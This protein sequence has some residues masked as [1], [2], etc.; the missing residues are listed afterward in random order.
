METSTRIV[1]SLNELLTMELTA[2]NQYFLHSR[3]C[4]SWGYESLAG[5]LRDIAFDEMRDAEQLID[6]LLYVGTIPN[7]QRMGSVKIGETVPEQL[8]L[9]RETERSA[10]ELLSRAIA[11]CVED[12]DQATRE[13]LAAKLADEEKHLE[14][15]ETQLGLIERVGE[16]NYL[17]RQI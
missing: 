11:V 7:V 5:H 6:R 1:E 4:A 16:Q 17:T 10:L 15:H 12:G 13:F 14:W 2:V 9:Q 3:L 8:S